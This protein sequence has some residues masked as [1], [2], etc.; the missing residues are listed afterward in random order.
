[1]YI[2]SIIVVSYPVFS[3]NENMK[4]W[5]EKIENSTEKGIFHIAQLSDKKALEAFS[6]FFLYIAIFS[7]ILSILYSKII[8]STYTPLALT[9]LV[10]FYFFVSVRSWST[11]RDIIIKDELNRFKKDFIFMSKIG[12]GIFFTFLLFAYLN[13]ENLPSSLFNI[14]ELMIFIPSILAL[15]LISVFT[16]SAVVSGSLLTFVFL[17]AV[18]T[19]LYL[20]IVINT[21]K[22]LSKFDKIYLKNIFTVYFIIVSVGRE[23]AKYF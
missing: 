18:T 1:M 19:I 7:F 12:I 4:V 17:P 14:N 9:A 13:I 20:K 8:G 5:I 2:I 3:F 6:Q 10:F 22:L 16:M 15:I 11:R 23:V 21:S